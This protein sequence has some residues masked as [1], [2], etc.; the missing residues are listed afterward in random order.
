[1]RKGYVHHIPHN[2]KTMRRR[3]EL[4]K[5]DLAK[6]IKLKRVKTID[7]WEKGQEPSITN[8]LTLCETFNMALKTFV[9][10]K[11]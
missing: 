10:K 8:I 5:V 9:L 4:T 3:M 7:D 1:M 11:L 6:R 2:I